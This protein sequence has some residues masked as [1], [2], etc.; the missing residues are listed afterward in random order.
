MRTG[1]KYQL[2]AFLAASCS[3]SAFAADSNNAVLQGLPITGRVFSDVYAPIKDVDTAG[4][5]QVSTSLWL[6]G[7]TRMGEYGFARF[8]L[9]GDALEAANVIGTPGATNTWQLRTQLREGYA[10]YARN[11]WQI[12]FGRQILPWGKAD[13]INPTDFLSAKDFTFFNPDDEV[14]RIGSTSFVVDWTPSAGNSPVTF[15]A[16]I[17][18]V[19]A[20]SR[21]L[22][23]PSA[24]PAGIVFNS[25][26]ASPTQTLGNTETAFKAAYN[27]GSW[28]ASLL[29]F[30]G[31]NHFPEFTI[32]A[33]S[34][35]AGTP[36]AVTAN[37][38]Q[39]FNHIRALGGDG[40][41]TA[42]KWI[43]RGE[44]SYTWTQNDDGANALIQPTHWDSVVG[45]ER[46]IGDDFRV[47][48]QFV[49]RLIP[50]F[51][52]PAQAG[53]ANPIEAS[54]RSQVAQANALLLAYQFKSRPGATFRLS[55]AHEASGVEAELFT[56]GNFVGG[57][58]LLRPKL[59][60]A[61]T[62][63][64]KTTVGV[65]YYGGPVNRPL[66]ALQTYNSAF[67]EGK[68]VF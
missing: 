6:Q 53:G 3:A 22:I 67:V 45:A 16:V 55:Y 1:M 56:V 33:I 39:S 10:G 35:G 62:D 12:R 28:D 29:A 27:G 7:D 23:P 36:P 9:S 13:A 31:F 5:R 64:L 66:G 59:G 37:I 63:A 49:Y 44:T 50:D 26:P 15:T 68:Y 61:W 43:V 57:D 38:G 51:N 19:F 21:L 24:V 65:D 11:G 41:F 54:I 58:Y 17:T 40:S 47:Q 2:V 48:A 30:R 60:Y 34:I 14:R 25:S 4:Y 18:P 52:E 46:P 8:I 20:Q 32:G 42:G